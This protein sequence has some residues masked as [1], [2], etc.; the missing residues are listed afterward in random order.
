M[1]LPGIG[2]TR[3]PLDADPPDPSLEDEEFVNVVAQ[4][5]GM[6][7][8]VRQELLERNTLVERARALADLLEKK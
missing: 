3:S 5:L 6:P 7:E 2:E 1:T 4:T 8:A